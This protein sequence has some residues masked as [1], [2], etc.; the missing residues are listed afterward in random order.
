MSAPEDFLKDIGVRNVAERLSRLAK[1][2]RG[3]MITTVE[4]EH[5]GLKEAINQAIQTHMQEKG[6]NDGGT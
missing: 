3:A 5:P 1:Y 6:T 2:S 4:D